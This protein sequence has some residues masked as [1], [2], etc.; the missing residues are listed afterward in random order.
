M[1]STV[2]MMTLCALTASGGR[3][4]KSL[5]LASGRAK[6]ER[7]WLGVSIQPVTEDIAAALGPDAAKGALIADVNADSPSAK[8]G[9]KRGDVVTAVDG[10]AV[11]SPGDL[12]RMIATA[13]PGAEAKL[14][15]LRGC[16]PTELTFTL[17][18]RG[19]QPA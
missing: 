13:K 14:D 12:T 2:L 16:K 18:Q 4:A 7:G 11:D 1:P 17:G 6:V 15:F 9:L 8:A 5:R 19:D 3:A 10:H